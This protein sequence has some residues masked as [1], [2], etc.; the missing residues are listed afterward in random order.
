MHGPYDA[1][2]VA[3]EPDA[4]LFVFPEHVRPVR[5]KLALALRDGY[6]GFQRS[7]RRRATGAGRVRFWR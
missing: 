7:D 3:L 1:S 2:R 6:K 5:V 4:L